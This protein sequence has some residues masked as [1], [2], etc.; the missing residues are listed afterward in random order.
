M[1]LVV[2]M[3]VSSGNKWAVKRKGH[4]CYWAFLGFRGIFY[5]KPGLG[6]SRA[7]PDL[8]SLS[9]TG[10]SQTKLSLVFWLDPPV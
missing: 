7:Q 9:L 8:L 6:L 10:Q 2:E 3:E 1:V 4:F 5:S